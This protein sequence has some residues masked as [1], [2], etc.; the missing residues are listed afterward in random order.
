MQPADRIDETY[1]EQYLLHLS[2]NEDG[3]NAQVANQLIT[4]LDKKKALLPAKTD[5]LMMRP[6]QV[7]A[8]MGGGPLIADPTPPSAP[9]TG[10]VDP[11]LGLLHTLKRNQSARPSEDPDLRGVQD[12]TDPDL[13]RDL[14]ELP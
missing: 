2:R 11:L 1:V 6:E 12:G 3:Y 5:L 8:L 13:D 14:A 7:T 4:F 9:G 10:P